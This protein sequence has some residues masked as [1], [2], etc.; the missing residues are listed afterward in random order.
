MLWK[1]LL[2]CG[3]VG[4][5]SGASQKMQWLFSA[6]ATGEDADTHPVLQVLSRRRP[7]V[8]LA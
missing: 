3:Q 2:P 4:S 7:A 6:S 8:E 5:A 1:A